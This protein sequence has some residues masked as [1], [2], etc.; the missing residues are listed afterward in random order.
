MPVVSPWQLAVRRRNVGGD[1]GRLK[2]TIKCIKNQKPLYNTDKSCLARRCLELE[3]KLESLSGK[4][5]AKTVISEN[6]LDKI[7]VQ[8]RLRKS[9]RDS[10]APKQRKIVS[11]KA[12][13]Q[14]VAKQELQDFCQ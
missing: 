2:F 1:V 9:A 13:W 14:K 7:V 5:K 4:K 10:H 6:E 12:V 8:A 3:T 11:W